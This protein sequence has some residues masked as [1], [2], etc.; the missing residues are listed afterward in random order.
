MADDVLCVALDQCEE[1]FM[2]GVHSHGWPALKVQHDTVAKLRCE[3]E[4]YFKKNLEN[5]GRKWHGPGGDSRRITR[6]AF[7]NIWARSRRF[8]R[9][10]TV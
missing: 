10:R 6:M 2:R 1:N 8:I 7:Y 9:T 3:L 4:K 5:D